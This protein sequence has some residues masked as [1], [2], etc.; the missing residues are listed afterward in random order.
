MEW[1]DRA[2]NRVEFRQGS[3][4]EIPYEDE[5]FDVVWT[6]HVQPWEWLSRSSDQA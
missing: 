4:L 2:Y 5:W 1:K 3:A 6:E